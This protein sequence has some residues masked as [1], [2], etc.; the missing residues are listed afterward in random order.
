MNVDNTNPGFS[1]WIRYAASAR[2]S[3]ELFDDTRIPGIRE[4]V[5]SP[6]CGSSSRGTSHP[7]GT[8]MEEV[9]G[10][11]FVPPVGR[12]LGGTT[13]PRATRD[14]MVAGGWFLPPGSRPRRG[15]RPDSPG[16]ET[17]GG[18]RPTPMRRTPQGCH[19]PCCSP[20]DSATPSG[21]DG[22]AL[23]A[24]GVFDPGLPNLRRLRRRHPPRAAFSTVTTA[25]SG[26]QGAS[27][28]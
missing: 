26:V 2:L 10:G 8:A 3:S 15:R 1:F 17:R 14:E 16:S 4:M 12:L 13:H 24:P 25:T 27:D 19:D 7:R 22:I 23:H 21:S 20:R 18:E 28:S 6:G 9:A 5:R 11:W